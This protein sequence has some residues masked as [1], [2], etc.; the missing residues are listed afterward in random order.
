M[1]CMHSIHVDTEWYGTGE[2][3]E[4]LEI[5]KQC[6]EPAVLIFE[7]G[8]PPYVITFEIPLCREHAV[9]EYGITE[10]EIE[11]GEY[12]APYVFAISS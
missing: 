9:S 7:D 4:S 11:K 8:S 10:E 12:L 5:Y 3:A 1:Q 2:D 6:L